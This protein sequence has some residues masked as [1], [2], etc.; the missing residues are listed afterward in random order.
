M[1]R[2]PGEARVVAARR[3]RG[4]LPALSFWVVSLSKT[5]DA[6]GASGLLPAMHGCFG[7]GSKEL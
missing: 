6:S 3:E 1:P 2:S 5:E 7:P 4:L